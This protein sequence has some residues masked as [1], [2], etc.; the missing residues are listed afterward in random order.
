MESVQ[1]EFEIFRFMNRM[2]QLVNSIDRAHATNRWI[3][4]KKMR[5]RQKQSLHSDTFHWYGDHK[6]HM[7]GAVVIFSLG[8]SDGT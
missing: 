2:L 4:K 7:F 6:L 8:Q 3:C 1:E 5:S